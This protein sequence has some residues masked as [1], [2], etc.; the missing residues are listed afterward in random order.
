MSDSERGR[1]QSSSAEAVDREGLV[2]PKIRPRS[3]S[4]RNRSLAVEKIR[5]P[6]GRDE[7]MQQAA[8]ISTYS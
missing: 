7:Q 4:L 2:V 1:S 8:E 3:A 6:T 5:H